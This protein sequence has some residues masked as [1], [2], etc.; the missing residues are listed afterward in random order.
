MK[1][2]TWISLRN[3]SPSD[4]PPLPPGMFGKAPNGGMACQKLDDL[5]GMSRS[6]V[7]LP[8]G[9]KPMTAFDGSKSLM[10][11]NGL[12]CCVTIIGS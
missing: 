1:R 2:K 3:A 9:V 6:E 5:M 4:R 12:N 10:K 11:P 7:K 8:A